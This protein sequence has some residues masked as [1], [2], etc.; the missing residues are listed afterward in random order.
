MP[1][2]F[3]TKT[4]DININTYRGLIQGDLIV[5]EKGGDPEEG[6]VLYGFDEV[7]LFDHE[8]KNPQ[9]AFTTD[10]LDYE[11]VGV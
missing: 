4:V 5:Y 3:E 9:Y 1:L 11:F 7:G 6:L 8:F 2:M 10:D